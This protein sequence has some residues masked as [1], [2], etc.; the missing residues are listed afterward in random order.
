MTV[1]ICYRSITAETN[2]LS[3]DIADIN[4]KEIVLDDAIIEFPPKLTG[5]ALVPD[6]VYFLLLL[7]RI[8]LT[9]VTVII[10]SLTVVRNVTFQE[11]EFSGNLLGT[12]LGDRGIIDALAGDA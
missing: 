5:G 3:S 11:V 8:S 6:V 7:D 2:T 12:S 10:Q 1:V 9:D 4:V